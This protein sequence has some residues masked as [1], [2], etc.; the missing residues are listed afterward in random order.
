MKST[1]QEDTIAISKHLLAVRMSNLIL[2]INAGS[3]SLKCSLYQEQDRKD[4]RRLANA[5]ISAINQPP[6][7]LKYSRGS[8]KHEADLSNVDDHRAA[9]ENV[10]EAFLH[11]KEVPEVGSKEDIHYACHRVVQGGNFEED[12]LITK[13]TF[14][15]IE[16][17]SD[18]APLYVYGNPRSK[19][20]GAC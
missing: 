1:H 5:E 20:F 11:D 6:A 16:A 15:K 19:C 7:K 10:L 4:L 8:Y 17:L 13:E 9:F 2:S 18:L 12:Q 3:S 14:H